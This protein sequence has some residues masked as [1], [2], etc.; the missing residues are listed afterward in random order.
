HGVPDGH[1]AG[2]P[3][4]GG[5]RPVRPYRRRRGREGSLTDPTAPGRKGGSRLTGRACVPGPLTP[6]PAPAPNL[7]PGRPPRSP[8]IATPAAAPRSPQ[9]RSRTAG[10]PSPPRAGRAT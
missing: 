8:T 4:G 6:P 3:P 5:G 7:R 9:P 2:R 1:G 10:I